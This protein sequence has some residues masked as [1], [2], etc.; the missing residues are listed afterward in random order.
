MNYD[1]F[2]QKVQEYS[3]LEKPDDAL[4]IT[5]A[6]LQTMS[7]RLPRTHREH[8]AAQLPDEL[9]TYLPKREPMVYLL[10]EEF[11]ERIGN[12]ANVGYQKAVKYACAV[13][14][15]LKEA[16]APGE[17]EDILSGFPEEYSELFGKRPSSPLSPSAI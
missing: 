2:L 4:K 17:L 8:L 3:A 14:R 12:R 9:K 15:V 13:A 16:I 6:T 7:E 5:Q 10:L 1:V 11:Y